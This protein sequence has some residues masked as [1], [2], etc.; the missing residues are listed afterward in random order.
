M[1]N[2]LKL[3]VSIA[4]CEGAGLIGSFFTAAAIPAWYAELIKPSFNPPSW[5]FGPVWIIL[6]A[7]M[8]ISLYLIWR[9]GLANPEIKFAFIFFLVHLFFNAIWSIIFFGAKNISLALADIILLWLMILILIWRFS[10]I[11]TIAAWLLV[12]YFLW[13]SFASVLNYSIWKLNK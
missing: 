12:P 7:L 9:K 5:L 11:D 13:V 8:G 6:Y 4:I 2:T 10:R 1:T 3:I